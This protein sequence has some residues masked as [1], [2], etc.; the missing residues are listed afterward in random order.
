MEKTL[1]VFV[2]FLPCII[3]LSLSA[4]ELY[5][6]TESASTVPKGVVGLKI[7]DET[8]Q[9][10]QQTRSQFSL[11]LMYGLTSKLSVYIQ[12]NISNHHDTILPVNLVTHTHVGSA[13]PFYAN[14]KTFGLKYP[15]L[16][17]GFYFFAKYR[18]FSHDLEQ[19]HFRIALYANA[20]TANVAHDEAEPSL[21]G[22]NKGYGGGIII[23]QL[24]HRFAATISGGFIKPGTYHE[25]RYDYSYTQPEFTTD[26]TYPDAFTYTF[27]FG[28]ILYPKVYTSYEQANYNIY[29]ELIG[30]SY[31]AAAV[32]QN[33]LPVD[34]KTQTLKAGNY[35]DA[36]IGLQTIVSSN[37][38]VELS[39]AFNIVNRSW[40][41][42]YPFYTIGWQHYFYFR[43][44]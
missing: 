2:T 17:G 5:P 23:T 9:E 13:T 37:T 8:Y 20:S 21:T 28:Y 41:H 6:I 38:R 30:K 15:F 39:A 32:V 22:D 7:M 42:F 25:T 3:S 40:E 31:G 34:A 36:N 11:R 26:L 1:L 18:I 19:K 10:Y 16:F 14:S 29:L 35:L 43:K 24:L 4:Q 44:N 33:N 27:S 12:P